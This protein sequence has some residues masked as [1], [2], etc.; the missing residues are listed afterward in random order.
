LDTPGEAAGLT[1]FDE[2]FGIKVFSLIYSRNS[3][4]FAA[5]PSLHCAYPVVILFYAFKNNSRI[6]KFLPALFMVG[7]WFSALY[8]G[9]HYLTDVIFGVVCAVIGLMIFQKLLLKSGWFQIFLTKYV[10]LIN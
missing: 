8:S 5:L 6:M 1:R 9:H 3:N 2:L 10:Q 7:I 4:V